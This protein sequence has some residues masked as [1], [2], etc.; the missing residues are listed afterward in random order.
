MFSS[1][2]DDDQFQFCSFRIFWTQ[3][4]SFDF[5]LFKFKLEFEIAK[6]QYRSC[7]LGLKKFYNFGPSPLSQTVSIYPADATIDTFF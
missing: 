6:F 7:L 1:I 4:Q 3:V 5:T 2:L